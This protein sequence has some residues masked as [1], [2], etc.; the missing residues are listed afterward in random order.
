MEP[1]EAAPDP[2]P[3]SGKPPEGEAPKNPLPDPGD[4]PMAPPEERY[5]FHGKMV[6]PTAAP[7][8]SAR[9]ENLQQKHK[10][11]RRK[12]FLIGLLAGQILILALDFGGKLVLHLLRDTLKPVGDL[13]LEARVFLGMTAGI[14]F[15]GLLIF[16]VLGLQGASWLFGKKKVGFLTAVGRG[17]KRTFKAAWAV[18]LTLGIIGGTAWFLVPVAAQD[19]LK[20]KGKEVVDQ[21]K[22]WIKERIQRK[23]A[24]E[25]PPADPK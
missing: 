15:T 3:S 16:F 9:M 5:P 24:P 14:V 23:P 8:Q 11:K 21:G 22:G 7:S 17:I 12:S 20:K 19:Y 18:G 10:A 25:P 1:A 6:T 4:A 13:T 2:D